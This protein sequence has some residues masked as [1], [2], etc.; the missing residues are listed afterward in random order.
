MYLII[1]IAAFAI[2]VVVYAL[3]F[4]GHRVISP[5][6][7]IDWRRHPVV[8][9]E[10]DDWGA[11]RMFPD[12]ASVAKSKKLLSADYLERYESVVSSTLESSDDLSSL[13]E[14]LLKHKGADGLTA[15]VVANYVM[16]SPDYRRIE[17]SQYS[18]FYFKLFPDVPKRWARSSSIEKANE[19]IAMG[20]WCPEYHGAY[21][22]NPVQWMESLARGDA[23]ARELF[24]IESYASMNGISAPEYSPKLTDLEQLGF[25]RTG[26]QRFREV[27][28]YFPRSTVAP[29]YVWQQSTEMLF[30]KEG[31]MI[32][33]GKN[34]QSQSTRSTLNKIV[35]KLVNLF[36]HKSAFKGW[37]IDSGDF[38][39]SS[40]ITYLV[41]NV[42]FEPVLR[43]EN[44]ER[45]VSQVK[46]LW[47]GNKPVIISSHRFNYVTLEPSLAAAGLSMLDELLFDI[48]KAEPNVAFL[49]DSEVV[50]L[51][52]T[53]CST[54]TFGNIVVV[55]NYSE[56][57]KKI[58]VPE[59]ASNRIVK[60]ASFPSET[61]GSVLDEASAVIIPA[62]ATC[63]LRFGGQP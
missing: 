35:G 37:Q 15:N 39:P 41:R 9:F 1:L 17:E 16:A 10:S 34:H 36:G 57:S 44:V 19:G 48:V 14:V 31:V 22:M 38:C 52:R 3:Y 45:V 28:G 63:V 42:T 8:V 46:A 24:N 12:V 4:S 61:P 21:H 11:T 47:A 54:R 32:V 33:Q 13:F 58:A 59:I 53:G 29:Y 43:K 27:F 55:R 18:K 25:M 7:Q 5:Q 56:D 50:Q 60:I 2:S 49:T 6:Y 30:A 51:F 20:V 62:H 26:L 23:S 40:G